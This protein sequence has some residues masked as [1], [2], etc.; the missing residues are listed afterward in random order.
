MACRPTIGHED[1]SW[2][3]LRGPLSRRL[4]VAVRY[5]TVVFMRS[6]PLVAFFFTGAL[7]IGQQKPAVTPAAFPK[8][9]AL[10][11]GELSPDGKWL[12]YSIRRVSTDDELRIASLTGAR[13]EIIAA[14]GLRPVFSD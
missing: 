10:G 9:E 11:A 12:A 7:L 2:R 6:W 14:F 4:T 13:K 3:A 8:W 1:A 5:G